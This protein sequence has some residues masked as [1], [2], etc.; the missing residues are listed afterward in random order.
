MPKI[1]NQTGRILDAI[2][3]GQIEGLVDSNYI[4]YMDIS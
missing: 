1:S 4:S 2:S 3:A